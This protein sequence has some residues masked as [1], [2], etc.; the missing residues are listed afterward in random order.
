VATAA[1]A[2]LVAVLPAP[3]RLE[4][5]WGE[6]PWRAELVQ[7]AE[8]IEGGELLLPDGPGLAVTLDERMLM[9]HGDGWR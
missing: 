9:T 7:P 2:Q 6:V 8:R 5:A 3:G 1:S 4:Y